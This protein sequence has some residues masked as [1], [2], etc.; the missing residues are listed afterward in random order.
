M[1]SKFGRIVNLGFR[2]LSSK[3]LGDLLL[4]DLHESLLNRK[5]LT[6]LKFLSPYIK[7]IYTFS[8]E[9]LLGSPPMVNI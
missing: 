8:V 5:Y 4:K 9:L 7:K 2:R 6:L 3:S 1:H